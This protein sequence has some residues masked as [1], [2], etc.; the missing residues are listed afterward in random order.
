MKGVDPTIKIGVPVVTGDDS[1]ATYTNHAATN[2]VTHIVH[3]GWTP[4]LLTTLKNLGVTP[5]FLIYH[6]YDEEPGEEN[7]ATL[8]Q[9]SATWTNDAADLRTQ[10]T[11]YL[12]SPGTNIELLCTENN[13]VSYNPGKQSTSL[14][15]GL[16]FADS[17]GQI[18]Q[19][20]FNSRLWWDL[21]NGQETTYNNSS[22][23]YGWRQYGDYG[24]IYNSTNCYPTYFVGK[25]LQ[26][27]A[28]AGD[29]V[30]SAT[31]D[32]SLLSVYATRRANGSV[33]LLII[34]KSPDNVLNGSINLTGFA[35]ATNATN[36]SYGVPQDNA[37]ESGI[38]SQDIASTNFTVTGTNFSCSFAAY[39]VTVMSLPPAPPRFTI[40]SF[41]GGHFQFQLTG[42]SNASYVIQGS[43]NLAA[44][45]PLATNS[46]TNGSATWIDLQS[47]ALG[48]RF[49]RAVWVP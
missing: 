34:N 24:I 37:A 16:F 27:F 9:S 7:D 11:D 6:R 17:L 22:S 32:Y 19:T 14:V 4:V 15:D 48:L 41:P 20:E 29:Q 42:Q 30:I 8:L 49:Y 46:L 23:L 38:G 47:S 13:S 33:S 31:S 21:R 45:F 10:L 43:T 2:P 44:W 39:S 12:G 26:Y 40:E 3:Y 28:K 18:L 5:D 1:Y 36:Y 35:S 25:L